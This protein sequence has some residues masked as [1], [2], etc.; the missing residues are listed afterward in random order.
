MGASNKYANVLL[1]KM[2]YMVFFS[3]RPLIVNW[4][5]RLQLQH[6]VS[7]SIGREKKANYVNNL[8]TTCISNIIYLTRATSVFF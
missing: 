4:A 5:M 7:G 8:S 3:G 1:I 2:F 6:E